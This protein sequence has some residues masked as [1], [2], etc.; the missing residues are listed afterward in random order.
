MPKPLL[1]HLRAE[2]WPRL[3]WGDPVASYRGARF[4]FVADGKRP[5]LEQAVV[6]A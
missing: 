5:A 3:L 2:D 1:A 6:N 4:A